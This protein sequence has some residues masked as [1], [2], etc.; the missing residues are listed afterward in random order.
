[1][2]PAHPIAAGNRAVKRPLLILVALLPLGAVALARPSQRPTP[3]TQHPTP[4]ILWLT[5]E[6]HGPHMGCY[7]DAYA[8]T[9]NVDRLA[10]RGM[11]Y[12]HAWSCAPVCAPARTTIISGMYP[13]STGAEHMR[14]LVPY[15]HGKKMFPQYLRAAG[16]YC[17]N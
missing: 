13:P 7:G 11:I 2:N 9:P 3:N 6:D 14:S 5:S 10:A 8:T 12:T 1:M 17:S 16:Y 4:N 15:P